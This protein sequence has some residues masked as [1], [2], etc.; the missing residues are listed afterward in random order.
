MYTNSKRGVYE[1]QIAKPLVLTKAFKPFLTILFLKKLILNSW[2]QNF[3]LKT[4]QWSPQ[5]TNTIVV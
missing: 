3:R 5:H 4:P 2:L 1:L